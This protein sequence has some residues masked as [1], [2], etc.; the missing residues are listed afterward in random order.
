MVSPL[1]KFDHCKINP[2]LSDF[3]SEKSGVVFAGGIHG[4]TPHAPSE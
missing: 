4:D 2:A 1:F 3:S